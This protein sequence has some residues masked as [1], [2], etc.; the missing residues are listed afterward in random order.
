MKME[1]EG[2]QAKLKKCVGQVVYLKNLE[3]VI[4]AL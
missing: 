2:A 4:S 1:K 3:K